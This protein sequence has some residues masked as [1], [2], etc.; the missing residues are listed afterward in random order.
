MLHPT[1]GAA[2]GVRDRAARRS[3][4]ARWSPRPTTSARSPTRSASGS[5]AATACSAPTASAAATSR[6]ALR[7]FFEV[8]RHYVARRRAARARRRGR[9]RR[10]ARAGGDRALRDRPRGPDADDAYERDRARVSVEVP[11]IGD[12]EDVPIIEILVSPG[13]TVAR[14]RPAADARVRQ[15]DDGRAGAVRRRR[16][17]NCTSRS[18]TRFRRA[19]AADIEPSANGAGAAPSKASAVASDGAPNE[20]AAPDSIGSALAAEPPLPEAAPEAPAPTGNGSEPVYASPSVRR[21][22]R[23]LGVDL[24]AVSRQRP[25]GTDHQGR[26]RAA[27]A[28]RSGAGAA[29]GRSGPGRWASTW[30]R[31]RRSTSR[32][33]GRSSACRARGSRRSPRPTSRATG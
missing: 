32:S 9:D 28:R 21:L 27:G 29:P 17:A 23:E 1:A 8:D 14:R 10:G 25:Q 2:A 22:A 3:A 13:D 30:R 6:R 33:S 31:G 26:R 12:F 16:F 20:A 19:R 7:R 24:A 5:P 18:A 15:G 4:R 11:D